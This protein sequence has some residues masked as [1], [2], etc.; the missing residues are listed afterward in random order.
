LERATETVAGYIQIATDVET[1]AGTENTK[2]VTALK[3]ENWWVNVKTLVQ[4]FAAKITFTSAPR[5]N[6]VSA[7][8]YLKTDASKDLISVVAIPA[9]D[10]TEDSTHRFATDTEKNTW[11]AKLT[12]PT[13]TDYSATSTIGG[14]ASFTTKV[15]QVIDMGAYDLINF[16]IAGTSNAT[17]LSFTIPNALSASAPAVSSLMHSLSGATNGSGLAQLAI[18]SSTVICYFNVNL[19]LWSAIGTKR[20]RGTINVQK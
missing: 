20:V 19:T 17:S 3:L 18:G 4:T 7:S 1:Q 16:D 14:F 12:T 15:I 11:N 8:Q 2:A 5:F 13:P 6:S 9:T 10:V